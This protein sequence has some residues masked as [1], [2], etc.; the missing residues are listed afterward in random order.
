MKITGNS[1]VNKLA[2]FFFFFEKEKYKVLKIHVDNSSF[3]EISGSL[4]K[5]PQLK[6]FALHT[7][8]MNP[9]GNKKLQN[10]TSWKPHDLGLLFSNYF[11]HFI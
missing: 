11:K 7:M 4:F 1:G 10:K 8:W 3:F 5:P 2:F 9:G 6:T